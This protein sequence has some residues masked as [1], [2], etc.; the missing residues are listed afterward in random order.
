MLS[1]PAFTLLELLVA[2]LI[3]GGLSALAPAFLQERAAG[4]RDRSALREL[5]LGLAAARL[6]AVSADAPTRVQFDLGG[7]TW[8]THPAGR[9]GKLPSGSLELLGV[10]E[11]QAEASWIGFFPDGGSTGGTLKVGLP[12]ERREIRVDWLTGRIELHD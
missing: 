2:L 8:R 9:E 1:R 11:T 6:Q 10:A 5:A 7:R 3:L 4:A 12:P